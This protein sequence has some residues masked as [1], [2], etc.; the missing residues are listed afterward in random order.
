MPTVD[1]IATRWANRVDAD[2]LDQ[3]EQAQLDD[4]LAADR[5]HKGAFL[6]A[7]AGLRWLDQGRVA[8]S[9]LTLPEPDATE[10]AHVRP[11]R[12]LRWLAGGGAVAAACLAIALLSPHAPD[13]QTG[14]GEQRRVTLADGSVAQINT[15]SAL[16]VTYT[17]ERRRIDLFQGEA[18]FQVAH[19]RQRPFEVAVGP[20]HVRATGTAFSVRRRSEGVQV[21]VSEGRVLAWV[22]G[23]TQSPLAIAM[24]EQALIPSAPGATVPRPAETRI[25]DALAWRQGEIAL[26]GET[27]AQAALEFNRYST[28]SLHVE[29]PQAARYQLVGYFQTNQSLEFAQAV[30][31]LTHTTVSQNG[32][33]IIIK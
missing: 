10:P 11:T 1:E 20:V 15:D 28:R 9:V 3:V 4:W 2:T 5:R 32:S 19:N 23:S 24:G 7:Q 33:E 14:V 27:A 21:I 13:F 16:D 30:A 12:R 17:P 22:E 26:N 25:A 31:R 6:R 8:S 18:W 29:N